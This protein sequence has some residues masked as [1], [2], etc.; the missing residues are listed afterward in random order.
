MNSNLNEI[1]TTE[2]ITKTQLAKK[3]KVTTRTISN[4]TAEGIIPQIKINSQVRY[5]WVD[6]LNSLKSP[7]N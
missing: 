2:L 6:V 7:K 4:W 3:L 1:E 5:S